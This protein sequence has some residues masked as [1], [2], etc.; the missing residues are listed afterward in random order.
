MQ[1]IAFNTFMFFSILIPCVLLYM[2]HW[3]IVLYKEWPRSFSLVLLVQHKQAGLLEANCPKL[4]SWPLGFHSMGDICW[5][6][7]CHKFFQNKPHPPRFPLKKQ[8]SQTPQVLLWSKMG[9]T[10]KNTSPFTIKACKERTPCLK[11][12]L[13]PVL[14]AAELVVGAVTTAGVL[15]QQNEVVFWLNSTSI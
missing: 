12:R 3:H 15:A 14:A 5:N 7:C 1:S 13:H 2:L 8:S 9:D 6:G 11:I 10:P 4:R